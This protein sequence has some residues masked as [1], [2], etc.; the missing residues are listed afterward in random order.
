MGEEQEGDPEARQQ[1][2]LGARVPRAVLAT[3]EEG[4]QVSGYRMPSQS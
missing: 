4:G 2:D 3:S 1:C